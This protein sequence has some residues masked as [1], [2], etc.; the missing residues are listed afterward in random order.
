MSLLLSYATLVFSTYIYQQNTANEQ[1]HLFVLGGDSYVAMSTNNIMATA[2]ER[3]GGYMNDVWVSKGTGW[4]IY[5]SAG[6]KKKPMAKSTM[7]W[8]VVTRG[9]VPPVGLTY[10]EWIVCQV[11][12][13]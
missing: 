3:G 8:K 10:E 12:C 11:I 2:G 6:G 13:Q 4:E 5:Y 1:G 7:T 9:R